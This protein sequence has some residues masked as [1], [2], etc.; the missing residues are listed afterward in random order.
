MIEDWDACW[1][2]RSLF[3]GAKKK[4]HNYIWFLPRVNLLTL[5]VSIQLIRKGLLFEK[6]F[7]ASYILDDCM[8][9]FL[10]DRNAFKPKYWLLKYVLR[11]SR[12]NAVWSPLI[13]HVI[14]PGYSILHVDAWRGK[15]ADGMCWGCRQ[16][17]LQELWVL[18]SMPGGHT[19]S[20]H[21][22]L[23]RLLWK[24]WSEN[25]GNWSISLA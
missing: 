11:Q 3:W 4:P 5:E 18:Y 1:R 2:E 20:G 8:N 16:G 10:N 14:A 21:F 17:V 23:R 9:H 15:D 25:M 12:S 6:L 7:Y 22:P 19:H 13:E 24:V